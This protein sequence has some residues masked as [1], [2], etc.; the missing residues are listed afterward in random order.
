MKFTENKLRRIKFLIGLFILLITYPSNTAA[1][2]G[3]GDT[4]QLWSVSY[5]DWQPD[6]IINQRLI[7]AVCK[8][9][10][11]NCYV[12]TDTD[13]IYTP[14]QQMINTLVNEF[15]TSYT[16]RLPAIYGPIPDEFDNDPRIF[17][18]I[19]EPEGWSGY[20]DP[21]HQMS[22][23][24][25][26]S[27]WQKHS[28]ERE[29]VYL[30]REAFS[31]YSS[32]SVL[33]HEFGHLLHW[34]QDHSLEPSSNPVIYW[35]EDWID[36]AFA[37][38]ADVYLNENLS[39]ANVYDPGAF[40]AVNPD[41]PLI[42]FVSG[43]SYNQVKLWL[44]FMYEH[45]GG[46]NFISTLISEQANG[47]DGVVN[48]LVS[49]NYNESFDDTFEHWVLTNFLDDE[50]YV[51]GLYGY[52]HYNFPG[53]HLTNNHN[54]YP[55]EQ[56]SDSVSSYAVDYITFTTSVSR[57]VSIS[58]N[59]DSTSK[60]RLSFIL[61]NTQNPSPV[62]IVS[63]ELDTLNTA[64]FNA[65]GFGSLYDKIVMAVINIDTTFDENS[66]SEY[67]YTATLTHHIISRKNEGIYTFNLKQ[68]YP[69]PFNPVTT[70]KY[71]IPK[72]SFVVLK[73]YDVLGNE[74]A[75]LVNEK[76]SSGGYEVDWDGSGYPSGVYFYKLITDDPESSSG[77]RFVDVK[78]MVLVK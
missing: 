76:L 70:I 53:C 16:S 18:L 74:V 38:F 28:S 17:I 57:P 25:V 71:Q 65:N 41:L 56:R 61:L 2:I 48:T 55:V 12:F 49:L 78:K 67:E 42:H 10:G 37:M 1:Q 20:F 47:I 35:E 31:N 4:L 26:Y 52:H 75:T 29:I 46:L 8:K 9:V 45:Y 33:A 27:I 19:V 7:T 59:C 23:S 68:N 62:N 69:N 6:T 64:Y 60:F 14:S 5:I 50:Q 58:F 66:S 22:D 54:S 11:V 21:A 15:D 24:L 39:T 3:E 30:S 13:L 40:F 73:I 32:L 44:V 63:V 77:Q 72:S 43:Y 34:G 36:E 51:N